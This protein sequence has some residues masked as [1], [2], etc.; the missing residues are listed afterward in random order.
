MCLIHRLVSPYHSSIYSV[1]HTSTLC[2]SHSFISSHP[3]SCHNPFTFILVSPNHP[4]PQHHLQSI[5][6]SSSCISL[7]LQICNFAFLRLPSTS[8]I[9]STSD[10]SIIPPSPTSL[11]FLSDVT[12]RITSLKMREWFLPESLSIHNCYLFQPAPPLGIHILL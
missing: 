4:H 3:S 5:P 12:S 11:I 6:L 9:T 8:V 2:L 7:L 1:P 10:A